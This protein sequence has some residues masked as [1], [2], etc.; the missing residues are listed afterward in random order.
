MRPTKTS[1]WP[2]L[3]EKSLTSQKSN[4]RPDQEQE[5]YFIDEKLFS[6]YCELHSE[7]LP[8]FQ[9][10]GAGYPSLEIGT[11]TSDVLRKISQNDFSAIEKQVN[12]AIEEN[13]KKTGVTNKVVLSNLRLG[14]DEPFYQFKIHAELDLLKV[15]ALRRAHPELELSTDNYSI[16]DGAI[17]FT[18][19]DR[20]KI[21][22]ERCTIYIDSDIKRQMVT[23]TEET[24]AMLQKLKSVLGKNGINNIFG[25]DGLL[26][27]Q[28]GNIVINKKLIGFI[29][30]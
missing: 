29:K 26:N 12:E 28:E 16:K 30:K 4:L 5:V 1:T 7:A 14:T 18:D 19:S 11:L 21:K 24:Q 22:T 27:E 9:K 2:P 25:N 6:K 23:L 17:S 10:I 8:L 3:H 15:A 20:Q 13:L